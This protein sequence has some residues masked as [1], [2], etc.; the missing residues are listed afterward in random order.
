MKNKIVHVFTIAI[1]LTSCGIGTVKTEQSG[2]KKMILQLNGKK[3]D[4]LFLKVMLP[5]P[6]HF[7]NIKSFAGQSNDGHR[8]TFIIPDSINKVVDSY[9]ILTRPFDFNNKTSYSARFKGLSEDDQYRHAYVY[10]E[11]NPIVEATYL[12]TKQIKGVP[13]DGNY[14]AVNDTSFF[15]GVSR[16]EDI[17]KVNFKGKDSELEL[18]MKFSSYSFIDKETYEA[19]LAEKES[20][21]SK[22][23]DSKYLMSQFYYLKGKFKSIDDAK[24]IFN[25]F[26]EE[27]KSTWFGQENGNYIKNFRKLYSSKFENVSLKNAI[28]G[29]SEP[30]IID[31][32]KFNLIIFSASWCTPCHALIPTLIDVYNDLNPD[33]QMVYISL[34]QYKTIDNWEKL[35]KEKSIPWRSL[36]TAGRV[37]EIEDKYDAG[38]IPHMLLVYPDKSVKKIDLRIK[39]DKEKLYQLV[40]QKNKIL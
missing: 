24:K 15:D 18:S 22:Y 28:S 13:G 39:E 36:M 10:D 3:Y 32:T 40:K 4:Q 17:F 38:S 21:S 19:S 8:W 30:I 12:E 25:N 1:I 7:V 37:K 31:S 23:P 9:A 26:S 34:D 27:N 20:I 6:S 5:E 2:T 35:L 16:S 14:F 33:L 11:K 29:L